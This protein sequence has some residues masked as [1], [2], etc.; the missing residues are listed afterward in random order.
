MR[1]PLRSARIALVAAS[2]LLAA[3]ALSETTCCNRIATEFGEL[4]VADRDIPVATELG[5][6][7]LRQARDILR[8]GDIRFVIVDASRSEY[9]WADTTPEGLAVYPW[10]FVQGSENVALHPP[11]AIL[12]HEIGHDLLSR[13]LVANTRSG[14]YGTD[15]PDWIDE[16]VAVAFELAEDKAQRRCEAQSFA[17]SGRLIPLRRFL[18]MDHPD[19]ESIRNAGAAQSFTF[20]STTSEESPVFYALSLA[21][22]EYL[23]EKTET[24][25]VLADI[26]DA[27][28]RGLPLQDWILSRLADRNQTPDLD[29]VERDFAAWLASSPRYNCN[30]GD[31]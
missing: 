31:R 28:R 25:S 23:A 24:P 2:L 9:R 26:I 18:A 14:Q 19:L 5:N 29:A 15:A 16:S 6:Q 13:H 7:V 30:R 27:F 8:I 12:P 20:R 3:P 1:N 10:R 22:P 21:F 17:K 4:F 11:D